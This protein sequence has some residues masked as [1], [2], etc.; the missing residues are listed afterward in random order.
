VDD[1]LY[2]RVH[3]EVGEIETLLRFLG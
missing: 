3:E 2:R 1:E